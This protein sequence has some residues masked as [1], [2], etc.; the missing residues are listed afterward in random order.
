MMTQESATY[1]ESR[2]PAPRKASVSLASL[3]AS[4]TD[5]AKPTT[6]GP[7]RAVLKKTPMTLHSSLVSARGPEVGE[8]N[9]PMFVAVDEPRRGSA[10]VGRGADDQEENKQERLEIEKR[11]L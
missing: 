6:D 5:R 1:G 11:S 8:G 4:R 3:L 2:S 7:I 10:D 9:Q